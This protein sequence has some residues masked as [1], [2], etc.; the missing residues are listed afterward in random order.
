MQFYKH[1]H[2]HTHLRMESGQKKMVEEQRTATDDTG[3]T[4][5]REGMRVVGE[6]FENITFQEGYFEGGG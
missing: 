6:L 3:L 4:V 5:V 1:T 2:T